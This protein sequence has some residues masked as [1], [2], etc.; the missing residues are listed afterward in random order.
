MDHDKLVNSRVHALARAYDYTVDDVNAALD[1]HPIEQDR[2]KFL[3]RTLALELVRLD[4]LESAFIVKA[5]RDQDVPAGV[6]M[7]KIA[8]R[9][10]TLLGLSPPI[11]HAVQVVQHE[12]VKKLTSLEEARARLDEFMGKIASPN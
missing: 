1:R 5:L 6:L 9:R 2:D 7:V 8:E 3:K 12:P 4:Q 10:A 11:G